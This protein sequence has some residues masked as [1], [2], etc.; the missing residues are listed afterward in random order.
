MPVTP[1]N[2]KETMKIDFV[3]NKCCVCLR[4]GSG[5]IPASFVLS[6]PCC[7]QRFHA[8]C[9]GIEVKGKM[10]KSFLC[11]LC[12]YQ[13]NLLLSAKRISSDGIKKMLFRDN[14]INI[15]ETKLGRNSIVK[16]FVD[17]NKK[18]N[19][20]YYLPICL[21]C[22][23]NGTDTL[24]S[25]LATQEGFIHT[26]CALALKENKQI[27]THYIPS[28]NS[29][30]YSLL[31]PRQTVEH[32]SKHSRVNILDGKA[33]YFKVKCSFGKCKATAEINQIPGKKGKLFVVNSGTPLLKDEIRY[34]CSDHSHKDIHESDHSK[35]YNYIWWLKKELRKEYKEYYH[36]ERYNNYTHQK[37]NCEE[38][39]DI[40]ETDFGPEKRRNAV[41]IYNL[42]NYAEGVVPIQLKYKGRELLSYFSCD[43][44]VNCFLMGFSRI[45]TDKLIKSITPQKLKDMKETRKQEENME[46]EKKSE[47]NAV[48]GLLGGSN[49]V[50]EKAISERLKQERIEEFEKKYFR[51]VL[52]E[53]GNG[54]DS[55]T[56]KQQIGLDLNKLVVEGGVMYNKSTLGSLETKPIELDSVK[57][58]KAPDETLS[59]Q[60]SA[61]IKPVVLNTTKN[62]FIIQAD[63]A[64]KNKKTLG[65]LLKKYSTFI[66]TL[67]NKNARKFA[68]ESVPDMSIRSKKM[69]P[70]RIPKVM[71]L[72]QYL[73]Y[74]KKGLEYFAEYKESE[75]MVIKTRNKLKKQTT[76]DFETIVEHSPEVIHTSGNEERVCCCICLKEDFSDENQIVFCEFCDVSVHQGCY[77]IDMLPP[78]EWYCSRCNYYLFMKPENVFIDNLNCV[79]C[80]IGSGAMKPTYLKG[81][82]CHSVCAFWTPETFVGSSCT[83]EP[84]FG[85]EN[86]QPCA[87]ACKICKRGGVGCQPCSIPGCNNYMHISCTQ[88]GGGRLEETT[89]NSRFNYKQYCPDHTKKIMKLERTNE[90]IISLPEPI[91]VKSLVEKAGAKFTDIANQRLKQGGAIFIKFMGQESIYTALSELECCSFCVLQLEEPII[92]CWMCGISVHLSCY[93]E[94]IEL[95]RKYKE[96]LNKNKEVTNNN[97]SINKNLNNGNTVSSLENKA[98][99]DVNIKTRQSL[100]TDHVK[101]PDESIESDTTDLFLVGDKVF[102]I[103]HGCLFTPNKNQRGISK[104]YHRYGAILARE[105]AEKHNLQ[106]LRPIKTIFTNNITHG[107]KIEENK[108][109][110]RSQVIKNPNNSENRDTGTKIREDMVKIV[111]ECGN[112]KRIFSKLDN[113]QRQS[114]DHVC[115]GCM[116]SNGPMKPISNTGF[117]KWVHIYCANTSTMMFR[118]YDKDVT[119][120]SFFGMDPGSIKRAD[121]RQ[122]S[123]TGCHTTNREFVIKPCPID[124][125]D[126]VYYHGNCMQYNVDINI[127][128][129]SYNMA[130]LCRIHALYNFKYFTL[131]YM[132]KNDKTKNSKLDIGPCNVCHRMALKEVK[133]CIKCKVNVHAKCIYLGDGFEREAKTDSWK[134]DVCTLDSQ[135]RKCNPSCFYCKNNGKILVRLDSFGTIFVHPI[136]YKIAVKEYCF[137]NSYF[138]R[139]KI[140]ETI[141][142]KINTHYC[143]L[144]NNKEG[145][146][147]K[148][149]DCNNHA[150]L[151]CADNKPYNDVLNIL[152]YNYLSPENMQLREKEYN[153][154]RDENERREITFLGCNIKMS[155]HSYLFEN[156]T[157]KFKCKKHIKP[158]DIIGLFNINCHSCGFGRIEKNNPLISCLS[159]QKFFHTN[160]YRNLNSWNE[161]NGFTFKCDECFVDENKPNTNKG[162]CVLCLENHSEIKNRGGSMRLRQMSSAEQQ[163]NK[164]CCICDYCERTGSLQNIDLGSIQN[165]IDPNIVCSICEAKSST[166]MGGSCEIEKNES[167]G[168]H[169]DA[170]NGEITKCHNWSH[171]KCE[172][173]RFFSTRENFIKNAI[174]ERN[175]LDFDFCCNAH[176]NDS[177]LDCYCS[178][179]IDEETIHRGPGKED[180]EEKER[181]LECVSCGDRFHPLCTCISTET[182]ELNRATENGFK[183]MRCLFIYNT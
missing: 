56:N 106:R 40:L 81:V 130:I 19:M 98:T 62:A 67:N 139:K 20:S 168:I 89:G 10:D 75:Q 154:E 101:K 180:G 117:R 145:N 15:N 97:S 119:R 123:C 110:L 80:G 14:F 124:A 127:Y 161:V 57:D 42:I 140:R 33:Q 113:Y 175:Y 3:H 126:S 173:Q 17:L 8:K 143:S 158:W 114:I 28:Q 29:F 5:T 182:I 153:I 100:I 165:Y 83:L 135:E 86:V 46:K 94:D 129:N 164:W 176:Y 1:I 77:G 78:G 49:S 181:N 85:F 27:M 111:L 141:E 137:N 125:L 61:E 59:N 82:W 122:L 45:V 87:I 71:R 23:T 22:G 105:K 70:L 34:L 134:C 146:V 37:E 107:P 84:V 171:F 116:L 163:G 91:D 174:M 35:K 38:M 104:L 30:M 11:H 133:R 12:D 69:Q 103:C 60:I 25:K 170:I 178:S 73:E 128:R 48:L 148:C 149:T 121:P 44:F 51:I 144:C 109:S 108:F 18:K 172:K 131:R 183:C 118:V 68:D 159:C 36:L 167:A 76:T 96:E 95:I 64:K 54:L 151:T 53:N 2:L 88:T 4:Y 6:C 52:F 155:L 24:Y 142:I 47:I 32:A 138:D 31:P 13:I 39:W 50:E 179:Y 43:S 120:K 152:E 99:E 157:Y 16:M 150:H 55:P 177:F 58:I 115:C 26:A 112:N 160:C 136:C 162:K 169:T 7:K 21:I 102:W 156:T 65:R 132:L 66:K 92:K 147:Y 9:Y 74:I 90:D 63:L 41:D 79:L 166:L 72:A 93:G